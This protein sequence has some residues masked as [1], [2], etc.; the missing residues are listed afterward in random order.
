MTAASLTTPEANSQSP[1]DRALRR[2]EAVVAID[3]ALHQLWQ[4][5]GTAPSSDI[6]DSAFVRRVTLDLIGRIPTSHEART[7]LAESD[8]RKREKLVDRLLKSPAHARQLAAFW[9]RSWVPQTEGNSGSEVARLFE[10]WFIDRLSQGASYAQLSRDVLTVPVHQSMKTPD[11]HSESIAGSVFAAVSESRPETIASNTARAFLG[12][13]LDCAQC[14]DHPFARWTQEQF[15]QTAAFFSG[16]SRKRVAGLGPLQMQIPEVNRTVT[17]ALPTGET[18]A[19]SR[20]D[21]DEAGQRAFVEWITSP[22]NRYFVRNVVNRMWARHCGSG[23]VEPLDDLSDD[24][25][26]DA[27]ALLDILCEQFIR[28]GM[29]LTELERMIVLS[30]AYRR[31]SRGEAASS[32]FAVHPVRLLDGR[33]LLASLQTAAGQSTGSSRGSAPWLDQQRFVSQ[34]LVERPATAQMSPLQAL[35]LMNGSPVQELSAAEAS[36]LLL[37]LQAPFLTDSQRL[38]EIFLAVYSR[39]PSADEVTRLL[40]AGD[41]PEEAKWKE[42]WSPLFWALLNSSEFITNH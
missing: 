24:N 6:T 5:Q 2:S 18:L 30:A 41:Q 4:A 32:S 33:Q 1:S 17:A 9:R 3:Q 21:S 23:I 35:V 31:D 16:S 36:P 40:P 39:F 11:L 20:L 34:F 12:L 15:W 14:H 22:E 38:D 28:S 26:R 10:E 37:S 8:P 19:G 13:N 29:D 27:P 7:F 25:L 42:H